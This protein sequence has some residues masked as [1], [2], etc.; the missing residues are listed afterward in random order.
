M[1]FK[2]YLS[3]RQQCVFINGVTSSF[4][5]VQS[6]VPQEANSGKKYRT[7]IGSNWDGT[8][9][10]TRTGNMERTRIFWVKIRNKVRP[11]VLIQLTFDAKE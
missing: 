2:A 3:K 1:W 5:P 11:E 9:L 7:E 8:T 10:R 4:V 6:G